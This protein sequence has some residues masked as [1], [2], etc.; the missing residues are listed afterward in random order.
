MPVL[1]DKAEERNGEVLELD[2]LPVDVTCCDWIDL[3]SSFFRRSPIKRNLVNVLIIFY[4]IQ[5]LR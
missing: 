5:H 2:E 4:N 3:S 1:G